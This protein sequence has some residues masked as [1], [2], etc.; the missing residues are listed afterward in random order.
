[1]N[2]RRCRAGSFPVQGKFPLRPEEI[3]PFLDGTTDDGFLEEL[4]WGFLWIDWRKDCRFLRT[5]FPASS[6]PVIPRIWALFCLCHTP[7]RL[8]GI[9]LPQEP[10]AASLLF[11]GRIEEAERKIRSRLKASGMAPH[12]VVFTG[13]IAPRR[14]LASLLFPLGAQDIDRLAGL[15]RQKRSTEIGGVHDD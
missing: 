14:L 10:G 6:R 7:H 4:L 13:D 11:S 1:M 15:V 5:S 2:G 8:D 3:L 12:D 9:P